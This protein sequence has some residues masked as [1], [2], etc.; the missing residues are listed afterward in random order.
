MS[1]ED[2]QQCFQI[3]EDQG[4]KDC[5]SG[6]SC[7]KMLL[8][9]DNHCLSKRKQKSLSP[10]SEDEIDQLLKG[11]VTAQAKADLQCAHGQESVGETYSSF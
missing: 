2:D 7:F 3:S 6:F 1:Y 8:H 11:H 5:H 10:L 9:E 4:I